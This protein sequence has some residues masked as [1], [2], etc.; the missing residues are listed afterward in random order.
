MLSELSGLT[1][2]GDVAIFGIGRELPFTMSAWADQ[3]GLGFPLLSDASLVVAE[4]SGSDV[5]V[6]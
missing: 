4:V 1:R 2:H 3:I 5:L 6:S